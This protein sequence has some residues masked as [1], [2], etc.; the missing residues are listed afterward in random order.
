MFLRNGSLPYLCKTQR[1]PR[2]S[3]TGFAES[4]SLRRFIHNFPLTETFP[5]VPVSPSSWIPSA[6]TIKKSTLSNGLTIITNITEIQPVGILS[7]YMKCGSRYEEAWSSG[8]AFFLKQMGFQST[9][10]L[11]ALR[12]TREIEEI[13]A[14]YNV[15]CSREHLV[16]SFEFMHEQLPEALRLLGEVTRPLLPEYEIRFQ[17]EKLI[18]EVNSIES[19]VR[20]MALELAHR[21]AFNYRGLGQ[22]LYTLPHRIEELKDEEL[23]RFVERHFLTNQMLLVYSGPKSHGDLESLVERTFA[24]HPQSTKGTSDGI[25]NGH[26]SYVGGNSVVVPGGFPSH[27]VVAFPGVSL[28][29]P[30][31]N[32]MGILQYLLGSG[33]SLPGT[34]PI[35]PLETQHVLGT[36][37]I[38]HRKLV[39]PHSSWI[40]ECSALNYHYSD[41]GLFMVLGVLHSRVTAD[42]G[43][44][45]FVSLLTDQ[46]VRLRRGEISQGDFQRARSLYKASLLFASEMRAG[47]LEVLQSQEASPTPLS[48]GNVANTVDDVSLQQVQSVA[49]ELLLSKPTF[50]CLG[51]PCDMSL[52]HSI[53]ER[54]K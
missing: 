24:E 27:V 19:D 8:S 49:K 22:S 44:D 10:N 15:A 11:S 2:L 45:R 48:P 9:R 20:T 42:S 14:S 32:A 36:T 26:A 31:R 37:G 43:P 4:F 28:R 50:V 30:K 17:R 38:L 5:G 51:A 54:L 7:L 29:D 23:R 52:V 40:Y 3:G 47:F 21:V 39:Q 35:S 41:Q 18:Q 25:S 46:L 33:R 13:G 53:S 16:Y 6:P 34:G 1:F 12:L